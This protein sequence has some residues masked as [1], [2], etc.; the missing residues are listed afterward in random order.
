MSIFN[1]ISIIDS[2]QNINDRSNCING[3]TGTNCLNQITQES[4]IDENYH[5]SSDDLHLNLDYEIIQQR[6][7]GSS[8]HSGV[9][10]INDTEFYN[11]NGNM[12][13]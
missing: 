13:L 10:V 11:M 4:Y 6:L 2:I 3:D 7:G 9:I 5:L 8:I 12:Q 1:N